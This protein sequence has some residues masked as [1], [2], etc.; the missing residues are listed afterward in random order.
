MIIVDELIFAIC[1]GYFV[2]GRELMSQGMI[3]KKI[4]DDI[5]N[6]YDDDI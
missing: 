4:L 5:G 6:E 3:P 2:H 1:F